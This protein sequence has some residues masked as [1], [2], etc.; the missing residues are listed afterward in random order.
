MRASWFSSFLPMSERVCVCVCVCDRHAQLLCAVMWS[1]V[2]AV[3]CALVAL[4]AAMPSDQFEMFEAKYNKVYAS[5]EER[6]YRM[7]VFA[8]VRPLTDWPCWRALLTVP[9]CIHRPLPALSC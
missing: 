9:P 7:Q 3:L 1:R 6:Q 8:Q 2:G 5:K 4:A